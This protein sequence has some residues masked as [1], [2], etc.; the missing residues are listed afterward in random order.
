MSL[1]KLTGSHI[2][3]TFKIWR[4]RNRNVRINL[5]GN[6]LANVTEKVIADVKDIDSGNVDIRDGHVDDRM[7]VLVV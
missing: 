3:N 7:N 6:K 5:N 1:E 2:E 4:S